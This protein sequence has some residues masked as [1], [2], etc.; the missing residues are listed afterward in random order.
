ME[1]ADLAITSQ[2]RTVYELASLGIPSIVLAQNERELLH[3]FAREENGFIN[4]GLGAKVDTK[5]I[6][7]TL[8]KI[9]EDYSKRKEMNKKMLSKELKKGITREIN[10]IL[11]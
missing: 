6:D 3:T 2:G 5:E 10:L 8:N 7:N 9:I 4:M 11:E 1:K